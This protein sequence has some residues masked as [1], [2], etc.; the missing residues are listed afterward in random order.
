M[1]LQILA[2]FCCFFTF[3]QAVF[4]Q[5]PFDNYQPM[6]SVGDLPA[7]FHKT[8][9]AKVEKAME[10]STPNQFANKRTAE[11]FYYQNQYYV[12]ALITSGDVMYGDVVTNYLQKVLDHVLSLY[13]ETN[14]NI[15]VYTVRS[16]VFNAAATQDGILLVNLGLMA[17]V[18]NEAQLAFILAHEIIHSEEN[19]VL[20]SF[21]LNKRVK[22]EKRKRYNEADQLIAMSTYSKSVEF[23]ADLEA[24]KR[25]FGKSEYD[26]R[27]ALRVMD[28]MLYS[29]LPFDEI[30]F[31]NTFFNNG[32]MS[33][34]PS[35]FPQSVNP[36]TAIEDFND[37]L[38]THPNLRARKDALSK[39]IEKLKKKPSQALFLL[40]EAAFDH[41][42]ITAQ[43]ELC[44]IFLNNRQYDDAI[45]NA[46]LLLQEF[47]NNEYLKQI[48]GASLY[49]MTIYKN[50]EYTEFLPK[51]QDVE[52]EK[53][54]VVAFLDVI[55]AFELNILAARYNYELFKS[56][57]ENKEAKELAQLSLEELINFHEV[58]P[59]YFTRSFPE[60]IEE[61]EIK[62]TEL[63]PE[64]EDYL[65]GRSKKVSAL[66]EQ[67]SKKAESTSYALVDLFV[68]DTAFTEAFD[69]E[70]AAFQK[71]KSGSNYVSL[72]TKRTPKKRTRFIPYK[73]KIKI[74]EKR[75]EYMQKEQPPIEKVVV[76]APNA[77]YHT[78][79]R[80][81]INY[82]TYENYAIYDSDFKKTAQEQETAR[83]LLIKS[84]DLSGL[85]YDYM[86]IK[87]DMTNEQFN[88]FVTLQAW[89][90]EF[91]AHPLEDNRVMENAFIDD[92]V[93][94]YGTPYVLLNA[95][96]IYELP[97]NYFWK[98]FGTIIGGAL[99]PSLSPI[100]GKSIFRKS[101][102]GTQ[103]VVLNV[104]DGKIRT[105]RTFERSGATEIAR[106]NILYGQFLELKQSADSNTYKAN[107]DQN[108][109]DHD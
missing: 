30:P 40:D 24:F 91:F 81:R 39:E 12:D 98:P 23:E 83:K 13:G 85:E 17:Q 9:K 55:P 104:R 28:V 53:M 42:Q 22:Q 67:T 8:L 88:D 89:I 80:F 102:F 51:V 36:I 20:E 79:T 48:I 27:E 97:K 33:L 99:L 77:T 18:E 2:T 107:N 58:S 52:G 65:V 50:I 86:D 71:K 84:L 41:A 25:V 29:Y 62:E 15:R 45:Y 73:E 7:D 21:K 103:I 56:F 105:I 93:E 6:Q 63:A 26:Y 106:T 60:I 101:L 68:D 35:Y 14:K 95:Q 90:H 78:N 5:S 16:A 92:F 43:F 54:A 3:S 69:S 38:A 72:K 47:P 46:F 34:D 59:D 94:R 87:G 37:S 1:R 100:I 108:T 109:T 32:V 64:S 49:A 10:A 4:G 44:R 70:M 19:H 57:P 75:E 31:P 11:E 74:F 61:E 66:K 82:D 96:S 76:L